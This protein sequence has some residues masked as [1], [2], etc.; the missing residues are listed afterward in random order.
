VRLPDSRVRLDGP[1]SAAAARI[2]PRKRKA[3]RIAI[4]HALGGVVA[5]IEVVS[6]GNKDSKHA[7]ALFVA[8]AVNFTPTIRVF[9]PPA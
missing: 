4:H 1:P 3:N 7:L 8:K 6:P 2:R 9:R 5:M